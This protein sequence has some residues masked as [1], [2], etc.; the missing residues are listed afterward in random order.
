MTDA[1][2]ERQSDFPLAVLMRH[3]GKLLD[4]RLRERLGELNFP[5]AQGRLLRLLDRHDGLSQAALMGMMRVSAPT[6]SGVIDRL[7]A[8]GLVSRRADADDQRLV[9]VYLTDRG[10]GRARAA[11]QAFEQVERDLT[12]GLSASRLRSAHALLR[13]L[14]TNL[15]GAAPGQEPPVSRIVPAE[16]STQPTDTKGET[17]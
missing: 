9:R 1:A 13:T 17:S 16:P 8:A 11:R 6:V 5:P 15:G 14:R 4:D 10:R 12:A 7:V 2:N 3:V